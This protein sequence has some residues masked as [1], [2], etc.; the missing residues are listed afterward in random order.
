MENLKII[1]LHLKNILDFAF[2][3]KLKKME[4]TSM[5]RVLTLV[6]GSVGTSP[7]AQ[8]V[9]SAHSAPA[10]PTSLIYIGCLGHVCFCVCDPWSRVTASIRSV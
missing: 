7:F 8:T 2:P 4:S 5:G 1:K 9:P 6:E 10:G 3:L